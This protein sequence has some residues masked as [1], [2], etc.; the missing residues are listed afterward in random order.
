MIGSSHSPVSCPVPPA[1]KHRAMEP[2][3]AQFS[4]L[5]DGRM[6]CESPRTAGHLNLLKKPSCEAR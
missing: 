6:N 3:V 5:R 2:A 1:E 4:S